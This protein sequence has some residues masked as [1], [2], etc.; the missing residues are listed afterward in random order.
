MLFSFALVIMALPCLAFAEGDVASNGDTAFVTGHVASVSTTAGEQYYIFIESAL[1]AANTA[2][3]AT[4]TLLAD[5]RTTATLT[6]TG[7]DITLDLNGHGIDADGGEFSVITVNGSATLTLTDSNSTASN[8]V[9]ST[10]VSGGYITGGRGYQNN[11]DASAYNWYFYGGGV[12]VA[13]SGNFIMSGGTILGNA[14]NIDNQDQYD[15]ADTD[16]AVNQDTTYIYGGGVYVAI[17]G[18]FTMY[19]GAITENDVSV[20]DPNIEISNLNY[21]LESSYGG[22]VYV[23]GNFIMLGGEITGNS[24]D[25]GGGVYLKRGNFAMTGGTIDGNNASSSNSGD[26]VHY[27][28]GTFSVSDSP[29][30][31]DNGDKGLYL[32]G[33]TLTVDAALEE[34]A[35]IA[36][37]ISTAANDQA[38]V[39]K[40]V[41]IA[42][43]DEYD[44][45]DADSAAFS[46]ASGSPSNGTAVFLA[47]ASKENILW[48]V[49]PTLTVTY[50]S[51]TSTTAQVVYNLSCDAT[52][53][54]YALTDANGEAI[55]AIADESG[56]S[57]SGTTLTVTEAGTYYVSAMANVS[58]L[59][60]MAKIA[61][62]A[63]TFAAN[64]G[65][66]SENAQT[67]FLLD[68]SEQITL[69]GI[70]RAGYTLTGWASDDAD[71]LAADAT[72]LTASASATYTATWQ[73]ITPN[74]SI[75][76]TD[77]DTGA[78]E[79]SDGV[80]TY[81]D[82]VKLE[83]DYI[84]VT[85]FSYT[86]AW[87]LVDP[88][89]RSETLY[90]TEKSITL[91]AVADSGNYRLA[92]TVTD[93]ADP[94][95]TAFAQVD[96]DVTINKATL[97]VVY[98]TASN[99]TYGK[100]LASSTLSGGSS[101]YGTFAWE[102]STTVPELGTTEH[103]VLF[104]PYDDV[105]DNYEVPDEAL[106]A[107]VSVTAK[108]VSSSSSSTTEEPTSPATGH[109]APLWALCAV[110]ISAAILACAS[111][112]KEK[113]KSYSDIER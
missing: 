84:A 106:Q 66:F 46:V 107:F 49:E 77:S 45:T 72:T 39:N 104:E 7:S 36:I 89:D 100:T 78:G 51:D 58:G 102:D 76:V 31:T 67:V 82:T 33:K 50:N 34:D 53:V 9:G 80:V 90:S 68:G 3:T 16:N 110:A 86:Y 63:V 91:T 44:L 41:I 88:T 56:A 40:T 15:D 2:G 14:E 109:R 32:N 79:V 18:N 23:E 95:S 35:S 30:I 62:Y 69:P 71:D 25:E 81:G 112:K 105:L 19:D 21:S 70:S 6:F 38:T 111:K 20:T 96:Q 11:S 113:T 8:T 43:G 48:A 108:K 10:S 101:D 17:V 75:T 22:G 74:V 5:V 47:S 28:G 97:T 12:Y 54:S 24:A 42:N 61:V 99:I 85:G 87:Y 65:T 93:E 27:A 57:I 98:P 64:G 92:L 1:A 103:N 59:T 60:D 55:A 26:G 73:I 4:I 94:T 83:A 13:S 37:T 29:I 52:D